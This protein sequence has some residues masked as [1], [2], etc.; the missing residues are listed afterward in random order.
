MVRRGFS[1][2][3]V[4]KMETWTHRKQIR[5]SEKVI[6]SLVGIADGDDKGIPIFSW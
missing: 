2:D 3:L 4:I 6:C 1:F 5:T